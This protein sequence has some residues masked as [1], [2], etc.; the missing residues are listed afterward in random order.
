MLAFKYLYG[1]RGG[2]KLTFMR[3]LIMR[4]VTGEFGYRCLT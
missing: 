1:C 4:K 3:F 2:G